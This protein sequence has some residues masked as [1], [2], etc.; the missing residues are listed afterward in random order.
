MNN[1]V[2]HLF[3]FLCHIYAPL[4]CS[5]TKQKAGFCLFQRVEKVQIQISTRWQTS[6]N[7]AEFRFL[8]SGSCTMVPPPSKKRKVPKS[9]L[10]SMSN[11]LLKYYIDIVFITN[12]VKSCLYEIFEP[13]NTW[14]RF[15]PLYRQSESRRCLFFCF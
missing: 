13:Y 7:G 15:R 5:F 4:Y 12:S 9:G 6:R 14:A 1:S 11:P 10:D 3:A 8:A 2:L